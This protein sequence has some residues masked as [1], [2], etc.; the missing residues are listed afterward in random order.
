MEW[1]V[2]KVVPKPD[3]KLLLTFESGEQK[4]FDMKPYLNFGVFSTLR[5]PAMFDSVRVCFNSIAWANNVDIDPEFL[6]SDSIP[7]TS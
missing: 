6:Y 3:Y 2:K 7:Q 5:D 4:Q 1:T